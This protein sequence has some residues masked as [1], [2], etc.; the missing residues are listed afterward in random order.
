MAQFPVPEKTPEVH[1][2]FVSQTEKVKN[3]SNCTDSRKNKRHYCHH[4][5][6]QT[7]LLS[8]HARKK[9]QEQ[10]SPLLTAKMTPCNSGRTDRQTDHVLALSKNSL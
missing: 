6:F 8:Q 10:K 4:F 9:K 5:N 1:L 3:Q 7:H 2:F